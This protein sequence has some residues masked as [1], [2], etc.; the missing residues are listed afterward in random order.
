MFPVRQCLLFS[1]LLIRILYT[2]VYLPAAEALIALLPG[3]VAMAIPKMLAADLSG[4]GKP[5]YA[6]VAGIISFAL[7]FLLNILLIPIY[8]IVGAAIASSVS[9]IMTA[10]LLICFYKRETSAILSDFFI[11]KKT[12]LPWLR[13]ML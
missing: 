13:G 4:R 12:D 10:V 1:H 3:I 5:H 11:L 8:G 6:M 7:N 2:A 9:Y